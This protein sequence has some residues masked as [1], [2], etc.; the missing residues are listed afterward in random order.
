MPSKFAGVIKKTGKRWM[1]RIKDG[2]HM[3]TL[4]TFDA[5]EEAARAYD[6]ALALLLLKNPKR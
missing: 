6:N 1:A 5:E 3:I 2:G 4:G